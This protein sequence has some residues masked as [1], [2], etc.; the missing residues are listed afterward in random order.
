MAGGALMKL[1][2]MIDPRLRK[3]NDDAISFGQQF[4]RHNSEGP[5]DAIRHAY[6]AAKVADLYGPEWATRLGD[7]YELFGSENRLA[8]EMDRANN[9]YGSQ[10]LNYPDDTLREE[11]IA[12][13]NSGKLKTLSPEQSVNMKYRAGG[14]VK[15]ALQAYKECSC[16]R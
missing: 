2:G 16:Q 10:L 14:H 1:A 11:L 15:S 4:S 7:L 8:Q 5:G 13:L 6:M 9:Q 3:A 12:A